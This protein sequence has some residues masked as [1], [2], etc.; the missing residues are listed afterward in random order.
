MM[1]AI[2]HSCL[3]VDE[4]RASDHCVG[5][6]D[7][8]FCTTTA[9]WPFT[10]RVSGNN[11]NTEHPPH[12]SLNRANFTTIAIKSQ[13]QKYLKISSHYKQLGWCSEATV[14]YERTCDESGSCSDDRC[15]CSWKVVASQTHF[16]A[17]SSTR[18]TCGLQQHCFWTC[19]K[20][21]VLLTESLCTWPKCQPAE[22]KCWQNQIHVCFRYA[23]CVMRTLQFLNFIY[24]NLPSHHDRPLLLFQGR[25]LVILTLFP[26]V[27]L[28]FQPRKLGL[29]FLLHRKDQL[30]NLVT[31]SHVINTAISTFSES[32]EVKTWLHG[33]NSKS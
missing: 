27:L 21:Y 9:A 24:F 31:A 10:G 29:S 1:R 5:K 14:A 28:L 32:L 8:R 6:R 22:Y 3:G 16:C 17:N 19:L 13:S 11:D 18:L 26:R 20:H 25:H 33:Q 7:Q 4:H 15:I 30:T 2:F 23:Q 12:Q